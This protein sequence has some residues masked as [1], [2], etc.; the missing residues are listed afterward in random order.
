M[1]EDHP[2]QPSFLAR[3]D[4]TRGTA[5]SVRPDF[6]TPDR[7]T[8]S[9][10]VKRYDLSGGFPWGM[11]TRIAQQAID[12]TGQ[13]VSEDRMIAIKSAIAR[14]SNGVIREDNVQFFVKKGQP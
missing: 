3:Q 1:G 6:M 12:V 14:K 5:G 2:S 7:K 13:D 4:V 8:A 11:I 10:E 9:V